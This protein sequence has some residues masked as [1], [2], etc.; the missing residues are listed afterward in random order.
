MPATTI[1]PREVLFFRTVQKNSEYPESLTPES[2]S[3]E[4]QKDPCEV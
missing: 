3:Q 4:K 1:E 2:T